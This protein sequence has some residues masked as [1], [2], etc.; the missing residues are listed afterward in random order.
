[1]LR[2]DSIDRNDHRFKIFDPRNDDDEDE[3]QIEL[4]HIQEKDEYDENDEYSKNFQ[5]SENRESHY[6]K[7][8][9]GVTDQKDKDDKNKVVPPIPLNPEEAKD[10]K[11]GINGKKNQNSDANYGKDLIIRH[12]LHKI[13]LSHPI[14][15]EG[16]TGFL[17]WSSSLIYVALTYVD[18]G[19]VEWFDL[20]DLLL[21]IIFLLEFLLRIYASQNRYKYL[22]SMSSFAKILIIFPI[23][24]FYSSKDSL[25]PKIFIAL[26]RFL[27]IIRITN[28]VAVVFNI[29]ETDVARKLYTIIIS[30]IMLLYISTGVIMTI[31]NH[32]A[33]HE[34]DFFVYFYFIV[35]T[36]STVGY[37][38]IYPTTDAGQMFITG[39][40]ILIIIMIPKQTNELL[41]LL[42]MQSVY[43]RAVYKKDPEIPHIVLTGEIKLPALKNFCE[44]LFHEDHGSQDK[45]AIILQPTDPSPDIEIFLNDQK[46]EGLLCFLAGNAISSKDL[47][48]AWLSTWNA[49]ILMTNKNS[50]D[51]YASDHKNI[52]TGLAMKKY[53]QGNFGHDF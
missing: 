44:E 10:G 42:A 7:N 16:I 8:T 24:I 12:F 33:D 23:M 21:C 41:R 35:V 19:Q 40:I 5:R 26:S 1:M 49:C 22:M 15:S 53:V 4:A 20:A 32:D 27:R 48:R 29:S 9:S 13:L 25:Y 31:E 28:I 46:Y 30:S 43:L 50:R 34:R 6:D 37:G 18:D 47:D 38:D 39:I 3:K 45:H 51:A 2:S 11:F 52:L 14:L 17:A 36:L